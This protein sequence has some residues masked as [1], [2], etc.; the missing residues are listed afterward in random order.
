MKLL[1]VV[2]L[3][4]D[5]I[6]STYVNFRR[7]SAL[8][9]KLYPEGQW[10]PFPQEGGRIQF[11]STAPT[12]LQ[13]VYP[14]NVDFGFFNVTIDPY[15]MEAPTNGL[16]WCH[17]QYNGETGSLFTSMHSHKDDLVKA[18]T[19]IKV[20]D[21]S[22][23]VVVNDLVQFESLSSPD[24]QVTYVTTRHEFQEMVV[25]IH[26]YG[27]EEYSVDEISINSGV[28]VFSE[29]LK[30]KSNEHFVKVFDISKLGFQEASVWTVSLQF[31]GTNNC[32][33][34]GR[35]IKELFPIEDWPK[36]SQCPYPVDGANADN[37]QIL[38]DELHV[39]THFLGGSC[40]ANPDDVFIAAA[41]SQGDWYVLPSEGFS[42]N[43]VGLI[44]DE[45]YDGV[46]AVFIGDESDS[47]L[48]ETWDVW[49]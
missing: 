49:S 16:D 46:A 17:S 1:L 24:I 20:V 18:I 36:S 38:K 40:D 19:Q 12:K 30:L 7:D 44:P 6:S 42:L 26:N 9:E 43:G 10:A 32:G 37:F 39:N 47:G 11:I 45:G 29:A 25:H 2:L 31:G 27:T 8:D 5:A 35:L 48:T 23:Q 22:G 3:A 21:A 13:L 33:Y 41:Q 14:L 4:R 34:G 15:P 28:V